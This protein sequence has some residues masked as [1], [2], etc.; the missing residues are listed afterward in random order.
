[1]KVITYVLKAMMRV[2]G[3][4]TATQAAMENG[5]PRSSFKDWCNGH[6]VPKLMP[7]R[8]KLFILTGNPLFQG[9][10]SKEQ[11]RKALEE[12]APS[13]DMRERADRVVCL[14]RAMG[15]DLQAIVIQGDA[16][17][18]DYVRNQLT[19]DQLIHF[20]NCARALSSEDA[21][22]LVT[23]EMVSKKGRS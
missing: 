16:T 9:P 18:R 20:T 15:P 7:H 3:Y 2:H 17:I 19:S 13:T 5:F 22:R 10:L 8:E 12:Y 21:L 4:Q 14:I 23:G 6:C 11:K 1:M